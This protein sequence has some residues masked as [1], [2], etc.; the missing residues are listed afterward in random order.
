ME[1]L[2][3]AA[4]RED[5]ARAVHRRGPG[6]GGAPR[7][8]G[9][10]RSRPGPSTVMGHVKGGKVRVLATW[11]DTRHPGVA[12]RAD[13]EGARATTRSSRSGPGLFVP[14][15]T[16]E[17]VIAKLREAAK[18]RRRRRRRSRRALAKVETP[19]QYLDQP[20]FRAFWDADAQQ[21]RRRREEDREGR[22]MRARVRGARRRARRGARAVAAAPRARAQQGAARA[23]RAR[24]QERPRGAPGVRHVPRHR[25]ATTTASPT[26]RPRRSRGARR[27]SKDVIAELERF[28]PEDALTRRTASRATIAARRASTHRRSSRTRST[29][30]CRSAPRATAGCRSRR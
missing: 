10:R 23:L 1:M 8:P 25:R 24:V 16:P 6:G 12:R 27:T 21:A 9:A 11:G 13:A 15:G 7:R 28:D 18:V 22:M 29:A 19:I 26:F 2:S 4:R 5:A 3:R 17:P 30:T 14:A 20:Q